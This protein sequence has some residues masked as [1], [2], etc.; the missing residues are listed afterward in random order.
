MSVLR[1]WGY[2]VCGGV[3]GVVVVNRCVVLCVLQCSV[4]EACCSMCAIV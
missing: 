2:G 4:L 3:G 1:V